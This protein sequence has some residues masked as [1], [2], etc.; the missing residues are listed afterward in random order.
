MRIVEHDAWGHREVHLDREIETSCFR[1]LEGIVPGL[2][3]LLI[4][5]GVLT[6]K[7]VGNL[8]HNFEPNWELEK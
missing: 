7:E 5:K 2:L 1:S 3:M 6:P 8:I 4:E